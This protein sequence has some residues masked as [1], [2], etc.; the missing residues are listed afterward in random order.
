MIRDEIR[1]RR[2]PVR[3][4]S[5]VSAG[6]VSRGFQESTSAN[7]LKIVHE[8]RDRV[9]KAFRCAA[10]FFKSPYPQIEA[11]RQDRRFASSMSDVQ[12]GPAEVCASSSTYVERLAK[13]GLPLKWGPLL[14]GS[15]LHGTPHYRD[16]RQA[17]THLKQTGQ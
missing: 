10:T 9:R 12:S 14:S 7:A 6:T 1:V 16:E 17:R 13:N 15:V 11:S 8:I 2:L 4:P 5:P 3:L